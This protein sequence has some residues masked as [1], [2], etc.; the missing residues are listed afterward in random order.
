MPTSGQPY[1]EA[2]GPPVYIPKPKSVRQP[3][4]IEMIVNETAKLE[5]PPIPRLSSCAYPRSWS[6]STSV[7]LATDRAA[8]A[9]G[10]SSILYPF[11]PERGELET[12]RRIQNLTALG[13]KSDRS[14]SI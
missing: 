1:A 3:D 9:I 4:R 14:C 10:A 8:P 11:P 12:L 7:L 13:V 2:A 6:F 5:K